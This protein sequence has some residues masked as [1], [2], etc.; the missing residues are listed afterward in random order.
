METSVRV[1]IIGIA[2]SFIMIPAHG[3]EHGQEKVAESC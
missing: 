2:L 1:G 3:V